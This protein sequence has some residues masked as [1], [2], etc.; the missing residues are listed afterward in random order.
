MSNLATM[1]LDLGRPDEALMVHTEE[2]ECRKQ[3]YPHRLCLFAAAGNNL[4]TVGSV[5]AKLRHS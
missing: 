3:H 5:Y 2:L 1:Y 4:A